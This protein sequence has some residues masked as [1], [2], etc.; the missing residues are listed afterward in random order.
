MKSEKSDA[1]KETRRIV[2]F[3]RSQNIH[4][5]GEIDGR[6]SINGTNDETCSIMWEV[7]VV[8]SHSKI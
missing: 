4:T 1:V 3:Q 2:F 5:C 6:M 8:I 7:D